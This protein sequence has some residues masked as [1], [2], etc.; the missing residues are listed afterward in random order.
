[1]L[2]RWRPISSS[3]G[4]LISEI[5][6]RIEGWALSSISNFIHYR[7]AVSKFSTLWLKSRYC[8]FS[9]FSSAHY[10]HH[11]QIT[12]CH[13]VLFE[14]FQEITFILTAYNIVGFFHKFGIYNI[15]EFM[16]V[17]Y[18]MSFYPQQYKISSFIILLNMKLLQNN[19][20]T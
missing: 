19:V 15:S 9:L 20:S 10:L 3:R 12:D 11:K 1:M 14:V 4:N 6:L 2:F 13:P 16:F 7:F 8:P 5:S 18:N 17:E